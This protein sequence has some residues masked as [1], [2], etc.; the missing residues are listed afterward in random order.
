MWLAPGIVVMQFV[1]IFFPIYELFEHRTAMQQD[2]YSDSEDGSYTTADSIFSEKQKGHSSTTKLFEELAATG[3]TM[4]GRN[5]Y[6]MASL[7]KALIIN[8]TPLL[9]FAATR[10]FTAENIVFLMSVKEWK[11]AWASAPRYLGTDEVTEH[12]RSQL[13]KMAV[14][15]FLTSVHHQTAEIP[16]NLEGS[17]VTQLNTVFAP[18]IPGGGFRK[19]IGEDC[20]VNPAD[21]KYSI[22][23]CLDVKAM[24][25]ISQPVWEQKDYTSDSTQAI[26]PVHAPSISP[27]SVASSEYEYFPRGAGKQINEQNAGHVSA[28]R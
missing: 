17:I 28:I 21:T 19:L 14:E 20:K 1:T 15:I 24:P 9:H 10:D 13:Y 16:L 23:P 26:S 7:E 2:F 4:E 25:E 3:T 8:P 22:R 18:N 6:R 27:I 11:A 5:I 12:A